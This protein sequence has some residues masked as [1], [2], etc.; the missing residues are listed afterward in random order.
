M[1]PKQRKP[2]PKNVE[3]HLY[4]LHL[5]SQSRPQQ[6]R[7]LLQKSPDNLVRAVSQCCDYVLQGNAPLSQRQYEH[8][9]HHKTKLRHLAGKGLGIKRKRALLLKKKGGFLAALAPLLGAIVPPIIGGIAGK[10]FG[11]N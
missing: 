6:Q 8:L 11:N 7:L 1:S 5:I 4:D 2:L 3:R 9:K 10:I